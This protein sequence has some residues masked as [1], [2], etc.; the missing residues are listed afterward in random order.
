MPVAEPCPHQALF[1]KKLDFCQQR[2][3]WCWSRLQQQASN[4]TQCILWHF[5]SYYGFALWVYKLRYRGMTFSN[6]HP[7]FPQTFYCI[8]CCTLLGT[9]KVLV[10]NI[11]LKLENPKNTS[12]FSWILQCCMNC[13]VCKKF[14]LCIAF[15]VRGEKNQDYLKKFC[16]W[17]NQLLLILVQATLS[18]IF[19]MRTNFKPCFKIIFLFYYWSFSTWRSVTDWLKLRFLKLTS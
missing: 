19:K 18:V 11:L 2:F 12:N 5:R 8:I 15:L 9:V 7:K 17:W 3:I 16:Q 6:F 14:F 1:S 10:R 4:E 13:I